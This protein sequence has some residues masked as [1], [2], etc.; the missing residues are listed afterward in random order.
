[1]AK[2]EQSATVDLKVR[3]KEPLRADLERAARRRGVSMNA[4]A[5]A[6]L[7]Q[8]FLR[9]DQDKERKAMQELLGALKEMLEQQRVEVQALR[10]QTERFGALGLRAEG[11]G[12]G[13]LSSEDGDGNDR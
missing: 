6:R 7:E 8:S 5:V 3:M 9:D 10:A 12:R 4:E 13:L 2:R 1:M 11:A